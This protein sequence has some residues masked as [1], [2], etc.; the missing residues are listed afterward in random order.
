MSLTNIIAKI[1]RTYGS[2]MSVHCR[3]NKGANKLFGALCILP[4]E[5]LHLAPS[6]LTLCLT[7]RT[8]LDLSFRWRSYTLPPSGLTWTYQFA[9]GLT[10][11]PLRTYTLPNPQ[12]LPGPINL[13]GSGGRTYPI[14]LFPCRPPLE[15]LLTFPAACP[16]R[17][18]VPRMNTDIASQW[19]TET[20]AC[21]HN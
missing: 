10:L 21:K 18:Y 1:G 6:G 11:C 7:L 15:A 20:D 8:Y 4:Q 12:D 3:Y 2:P 19:R 5:D 16:P 14:C 9:G 13:A 17:T